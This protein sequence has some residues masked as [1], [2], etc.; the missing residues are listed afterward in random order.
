MNRSLSV[1]ATAACFALG[2]TGVI[3]GDNAARAPG[4]PNGAKTGPAGSPGSGNGVGGGGLPGGSAATGPGGAATGPG[5]GS[6]V[7]AEVPSDPRAFGG[8]G[9][10]RLSRQE[11]RDTVKDLLGVDLIADIDLLTQDA[12]ST[13]F[14]NDYT[15]QVASPALVEGL[16]AVGE[17]IAAKVVADPALRSKLV[18]CTPTGADDVKCLR[19]FIAKFGGRAFRRPLAADEVERFMPLQKFATRDGNFYT[20]VGLIVRT[21]LQELEFLYRVEVG[22]PV[23]GMNSVFRLNGYELAARLSYFLWGTT[24]SDEMLDAAK[25]GLENPADV[26]ALATTMLA[27]PRAAARIARLHAMWLNYDR[28]PHA[29]DLAA[30]MYI[31]SDELV[32][33]VLLTNRSSWTNLF[34]SA[35]TF[36]DDRLAKHYGMPSPGAAAS[37]VDYGSNER[38]GL[39]S[40]GSVLSNGIK[41]GDTSPVQR[42]VWVRNRLVCED[43][44]S[45]AE[46]GIKANAD[47][48]PPAA[49]KDACKSE[50]YRV[51]RTDPACAGCH[52][53]M[54]PVG[55]GLERYDEAGRLRTTEPG[56]PACPIDGKGEFAGG[57][58][59]FT[60]SGPGQLGDVL[61]KSGKLAPCFVT[62]FYRFAVGRR[63]RPEDADA[64]KALAARF[65]QGGRHRFDE[66]VLDFVA[67]PPFRHRSPE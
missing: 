3:G 61:L 23:P 46:L 20:A 2:C 51:H 7:S 38:R 35:E 21:V 37:W 56:K 67:A 60:F 33:K 22:T 64:I 54:D 36:L 65:A 55:M 10:R 45:P 14:D 52:R 6:G 58:D 18:G 39:L 12:T 9:L 63:D 13:F 29:P 34:L 53:L 15:A 16:K 11:F 28:L 25:T 66:L 19:A 57:A 43:I 48:P 41:F 24:P 44:P 5:A 4:G 27:N 42:G 47:A 62:N 1:M 59:S 30:S 8:S 49:T 32:K 50:R 17:R 40:H 26:R 31:E